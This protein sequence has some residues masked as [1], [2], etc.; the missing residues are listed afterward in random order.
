MIF[1]FRKHWENLPQYFKS[2]PFHT[3]DDNLILPMKYIH[4][5]EDGE[6]AEVT[7]ENMNQGMSD[8]SSTGRVVI[9]LPKN[10]TPKRTTAAVY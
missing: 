8:E 3:I 10:Y 2:S 6:T 4:S 7:N 1:V 5:V 9:D